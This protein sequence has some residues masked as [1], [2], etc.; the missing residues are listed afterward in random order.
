MLLAFDTIRWTRDGSF[1]IGLPSIPKNIAQSNVCFDAGNLS[2]QVDLGRQHLA[3]DLDTGNGETFLYST[4]A[5]DFA[6]PVVH[7]F[8]YRRAVVKVYLVEVGKPGD[9]LVDA[10]IPGGDESHPGP[11]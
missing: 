3:F 1:E 6:E 2:V 9:D 7:R 8:E 4:F 10:G 5:E 11:F